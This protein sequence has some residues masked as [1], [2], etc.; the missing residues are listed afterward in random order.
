VDGQQPV[1]L[2]QHQHKNPALAQ[3][4]KEQ[5]RPLGSSLIRNLQMTHEKIE[6][7]D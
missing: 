7:R 4:R 3:S 1:S 2:A 6:T 5:I